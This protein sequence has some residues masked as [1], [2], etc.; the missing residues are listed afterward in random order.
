GSMT[1]RDMGLTAAIKAAD[2]V[3]YDRD[4]A[5]TPEEADVVY[6]QALGAD[7]FVTSANAITEE[8]QIVNIDGRGN[9]VAAITFGPKRVIHVIGLN[10]VTRDVQEA[11]SRARHTA[12]PI[13]TS[14]LG[15]ATPCAADGVCHECLSPACICNVLQVVR[16]SFPAGRHI[17]VLV[18]EDLGY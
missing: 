6:H 18:G 3:V 14:R 10:K 13:N 8:G 16:N 4:L 7:F 9:R 12:A 11:I 15:S 2:Y 1:I 17:V 5:T